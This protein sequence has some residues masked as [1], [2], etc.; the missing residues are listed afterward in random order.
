MHNADSNNDVQCH[1][2]TQFD[3]LKAVKKL[4]PDRVNED[5]LLLSEKFINGSDLLFVYI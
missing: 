2:I 5:G 3:V 1:V 4:K